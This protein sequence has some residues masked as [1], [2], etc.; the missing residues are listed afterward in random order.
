[1]VR[2]YYIQASASLIKLRTLD[3]QLKLQVLAVDVA[4]MLTSN[5]ALGPINGVE[6][7]QP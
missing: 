5:E 6:H 1:M 7:P 3:V 2:R 4:A